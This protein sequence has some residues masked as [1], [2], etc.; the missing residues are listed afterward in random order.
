MKTKITSIL[1]I[2]VVDLEAHG[3]IMIFKLAAYSTLSKNS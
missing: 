2:L 1:N 3:N